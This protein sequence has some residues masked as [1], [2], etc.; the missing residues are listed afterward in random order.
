MVDLREDCTRVAQLWNGSLVSRVPLSM[1]AAFAFH[2]TRHS[3]EKALSAEE[4]AGALDIAAAALACLV[5][6][7]LLKGESE[8]APVRIDLAR[9]RFGGGA[10]K[11]RCADGSVLAPLAVVRGDVL[12]ALMKI[13]RSGIEYVAPRRTRA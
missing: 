7:Y 1:A 5:P 3:D 10:T 11:V 13:E 9:Q 12:P 2:H 8:A 4:Y 6:I